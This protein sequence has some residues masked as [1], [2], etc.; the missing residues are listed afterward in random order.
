MVE[1]TVKG[2]FNSNG[3]NVKNNLSMYLGRLFLF[4]W[5]IIM[6]KILLN[7]DNCGFSCDADDYGG[8]IQDLDGHCPNC[9]SHHGEVHY[10]SN[11]TA[12]EF[13]NELA[14]MEENEIAK[15]AKAIKICAA[16][17]IEEGL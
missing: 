4:I 16:D 1:N 6:I 2:L 9:G 5:R 11:M 7:C 14:N 12:E 15:Y 3:M 13:I 10:Y 17:I 8:N